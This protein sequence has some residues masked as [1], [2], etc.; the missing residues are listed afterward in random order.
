MADISAV[1]TAAQDLAS[2]DEESL[3]MLIGMLEGEIKK[4]P[5]IAQDPYYQPKYDGN[6]MGLM[7]DVKRPGRRVLNRWNKELHGLVC[8]GKTGDQ[9]DRDAILS[10]LNLGEVAVIGAVAAALMGLAVPAPIAAALAPLI[11]RKFIWP[12]K[13]ELCTAW[14]E[15]IAGSQ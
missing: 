10:A 14:G 15:G 12:A 8:G 13:D 7:D 4:N 5:A 1:T 11:V 2:K 9:K 3:V 6:T